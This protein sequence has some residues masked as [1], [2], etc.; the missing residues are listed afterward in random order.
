[1]SPTRK[2]K[3]ARVEQRFDT[4]GQVGWW[5]VFQ[6]DLIVD[7]EARPFTYVDQRYASEARANKALA[8]LVAKY[9]EPAVEGKKSAAQLDA[10]IAEALAK[11][12]L[13]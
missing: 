9:E 2:I 13:R 8:K 11:E 3:K 4:I 6:V 1:M 10:E 7:G 12:P 5:V